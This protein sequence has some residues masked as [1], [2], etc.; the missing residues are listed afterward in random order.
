MHACIC[1]AVFYKSIVCVGF[2]TRP[3]LETW[4]FMW[5]DGVGEAS[6]V[7]SGFPELSSTVADGG[8]EAALCLRNGRFCSLLSP[9]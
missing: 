8:L 5:G 1:V 7:M 2:M 3:Y 4:T 6:A 9:C